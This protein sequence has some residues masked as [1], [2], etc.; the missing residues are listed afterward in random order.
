MTK[1]L[2]VKDLTVNYG[3]VTAI[4]NVTFDVHEGDFISIVGPNGAGKST[5]MKTLL[6]QTTPTSGE[7]I[8]TSQQKNF[9]GYLP[10][11]SF[12]KDKFFPATAFEVVSTGLLIQKRFPMF[13]TKEDKKRINQQ[14]E[15]LG[16]SHLKDRKI[17]TLS[18]GQQQRVFLAR[19]LVS[20]PKILI[21]DEPTSALDPAFKENFY[22][23]LENLNTETNMTILLVTHDVARHLKCENKIL[24]LDGTIRYFGS[25]HDYLDRFMPSHHTHHH[26]Y[27][28]GQPCA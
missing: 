19:A 8:K 4:Q 17:G 20:D 24:Y 28:G 10:Q 6:G 22:T 7:V 5:L 15:R 14:L 25:Y 18:G 26:Y 12:T 27:N 16:I 23:M 1:L 21:L 11:R 2:S 9:F 3:D 13:L